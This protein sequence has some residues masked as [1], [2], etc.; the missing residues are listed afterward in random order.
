[1]VTFE[2]KSK[3]GFTLVEMLVVLA[4][5]VILLAIGIPG[6]RSLIASQRVRTAASNLQAYLNL[7]R[8]E[9]LKRNANVTLSPNSSTDWT[10]GWHI[11]D[12]SGTTLYTTAAVPSIVIAGGS[13][14]TL[15]SSITYRGTGRVTST[16][17]VVFKI[18][19]T[20]T[21][22]YRCVEVDLTGL[23]IVNSSGC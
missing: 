19:A 22:T 18:S 13:S 15:P 1:V 17:D 20:S 12:G 3:S 21:S 2:M 10:A 8:A 5:V 14:T 16:S 9:A 23:A 6:M 7:T 11:V 4:I